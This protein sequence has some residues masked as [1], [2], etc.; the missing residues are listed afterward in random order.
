MSQLDEVRFDA[1][2]QAAPP[3]VS[4]PSEPSR[5]VPGAVR[6]G[7]L[8]AVARRASERT[9]VPAVGRALMWFDVAMVLA[10]V[11][12]AGQPVVMAA[13]A[14]SLLVLRGALRLYRPRLRLSW[15]DDLPRSTSALLMAGGI[16]IG[17]ATLL[18]M[19]ATATAGSL[20]LLLVFAIVNEVARLAAYSLGRHLRRHSGSG[21]RTLI[22]GA[23]EV[24]Q[25][26]GAVMVSRPEFGLTAVGYIDPEPRD[27]DTLGGQLP[28]LSR[29][30]ADLG[31]MIIANSVDTVVVS[32]AL[33][34]EAELL[35][36][37]I[38]THQMGCTVLVVPRLFEVHQDGPDVERL[39][40]YPLLRLRPDPTSRPTWRI[41][42]TMDALLS[43]L[44]LVMLSPV[45]AACALAILI[46]SGRPIFF[47]QTRVGLD[48]SPFRIHKFRSLKPE[49]EHESQ[50]RWNIAND[51][52]LGPVGK[53]L[54]R[55]SLDEVPQLWNILRGEMSFV[56]PR[57]ERPGFVEI[58]TAEHAR[59]WA[60]H[61]VPTGLT[62]LAQVNGLRGDTSIADRARF[63]NYYIANW[64]LWL[65]IKIMAL[66]VREVL[67][68]SG[69]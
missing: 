13:A 24:G 40:G 49:N 43:T 5:G 20:R 35:D 42:R 9:N 60:R 63:D 61:R 39:G 19:D 56:G 15:I 69:S 64:S 16:A 27:A 38:T 54:R 29:D 47:H 30:P 33:T 2:A 55:T 8:R 66:T 18:G 57:P 21:Q 68:G 25:A 62:G 34:R 11:A 46:E 12:L 32:F 50:T 3:A 48:G 26:L 22:M 10:F 7:P 53:V 45:L 67:R 59:Y 6:G 17:G 23:G 52:R 31:R 37:I 58:F 14:A 41:K 1:A 4:A 36:A 65:D 28:L 51:S 44:A